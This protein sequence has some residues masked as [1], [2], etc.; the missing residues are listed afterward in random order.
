MFSN[1]VMFS[2][3]MLHLPLIAGVIVT[4]DEQQKTISDGLRSLMTIVPEKA[5]FW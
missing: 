1:P 2:L 5:F 3:L 4:S